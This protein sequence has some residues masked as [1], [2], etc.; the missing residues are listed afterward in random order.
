MDGHATS[1][2]SPSTTV[3]DGDAGSVGMPGSPTAPPAARSDGPRSPSSR[4]GGAASAPSPASPPSPTP[5]PAQEP[6]TTSPVASSSASSGTGPV[7]SFAPTLLRPSPVRAILLDVL[8]QDGA[9]PRRATLDHATGVVGS[10]ASKPAT[11]TG[12]GSLPGGGRSWSTDDLTALADRYAQ[13]TQRADR[14][15]VHVLY[16]RGTFGGDTS[17]LGVSVRG[18]VAAVFSDQVSASETPVISAGAIEDAVTM[19]ELGHVL[20]LVDLVL[21]TGRGDPAHP[22]HSRNRGSV[23]YWA[24]ESDLVTQVLQGGPPRDFDDQDRADLAAIRSGAGGSG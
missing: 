12:T 14:A 16:L 21:S 7:G 22:G 17:V 8:A 23:M 3:A 15:V 11:A 6:S 1:Y 24:V 10:V 9:A 4:T 2:G 19:H 20:G 5:A 13:A 18:D